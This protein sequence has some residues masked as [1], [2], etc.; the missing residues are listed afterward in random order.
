MYGH[1]QTILKIINGKATEVPAWDPCNRCTTL[2]TIRHLGTPY[3]ATHFHE[4]LL[5]KG[6]GI[7]YT[8]PGTGT[9]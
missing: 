6:T 8:A 5:E 9:A 4:L 1:A 7:I 3:C 2:S